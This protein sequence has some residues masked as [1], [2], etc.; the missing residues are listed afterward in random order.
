[1][2]LSTYASL[3]EQLIARGFAKEIERAETVKPVS[4]PIDFFCEYVYV[5]VSS[6][7]KNQMARK[8]W[9]KIVQALREG[10][11]VSSVYR[12]P[13]KA[14]AIQDVWL[15][16]KQMYDAYQTAGDKVRYLEQL[17]FIDST[18]KFHL[19]KNLGLDVCKS[20]PHLMRVATSC[21]MTYEELCSKLAKE[22]G[23]RVVTVD[24][25]LW[26]AANLGLL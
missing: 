15:N 24:S 6:G 3:K 9:D 10:K 8:T 14:K 13:G 19:A 25:V 7:I 26:R 20:D 2:D 21:G 4:R 16:Y 5:L 1:M 12:H 17:P 23:D 11:Q 22:S 18:T